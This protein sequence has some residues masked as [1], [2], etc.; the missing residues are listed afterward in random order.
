MS[1]LVAQRLAAR[2]PLCDRDA[3]AATEREQDVEAVKDLSIA[4]FEDLSRR[5]PRAVA[6]RTA[7][8]AA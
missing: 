8:E 3:G 5:R 7:R 4:T 1:G 6:P 2:A